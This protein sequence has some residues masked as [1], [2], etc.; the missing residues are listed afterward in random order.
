M[1]SH[2]FDAIIVGSGFGGSVCAAR[3]AEKGMRVLILERGPWWGP[4]NRDRPVADR[5][6]FP[7]GLPGIRKFLRNIRI[8]R[9]RCRSEWFFHA[10]GL[11]EL[12]RFDHLTTLTSSGVGGGSHIYTNILEKPPPEFF[13]TYPDE[14]NGEEMQPYFSRVRAMLR[15]SPIPDPPERNRVFEQAVTA[16]GLPV[17]E[18]PDLAVAWGKDPYRPEE[19]VNAA[20]VRQLTSTYQNDVFIGCEDGSKTTL[21]LTYIPFALRYGAEVRPLCEVQ[22]I[23]AADKGYWVRYRDHRSG[24]ESHEA[25]PKLIL[26]AGGLNT[27]R[28]LFQ[29]R[30]RHKTLPALPETLGGRFS[31]NGDLAVLL[32]NTAVLKDSSWGT[33]FNTFT[34]VTKDGGHRFVLGDVGLPTHVFPLPGFLRRWLQRS[35]FLFSMGRDASD[36]TIGFDGA[37]LRIAVS[38]SLD[39]VLYDAMSSAMA[40]VADHY[41]PRRFLAKIMTGRD[42]QGLF[43]VHPLG[44]CA[45]GVGPEE[46]FTDHRGEVFGHPGLFVADGALYPRSPGIPPSM[47]IAAL[48]ERQAELM[49]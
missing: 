18:H 36:G 43:S 39:P 20:G 45:M 37:G 7:R 3:L 10:D 2:L 38:R 19:V 9:K 35:T 1:S 29:A 41:A 22:V 49:G 4:L 48:A 28:L 6:E 42:S 5:R 25:A 34:R 31:P 33:A 21:D 11:L 47:T 32:W 26:A 40:R 13:D 14:I 44:G 27:Q 46:G 12:H 23:G 16:A 30:H 17:A 15:P 8:A 24:Q